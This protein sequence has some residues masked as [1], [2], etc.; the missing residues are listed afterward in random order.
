MTSKR[1]I[2]AFT[3]IEILITIVILSIGIVGILHAFETSMNSLTQTR[4][5]LFNT[6]LCRDKLTEIRS[7][8]VI[9]KAPDGTSAGAF[10]GTFKNY[11]WSTESS[12]VPRNVKSDSSG[13]GSDKD[14]STQID[15]YKLKVSVWRNGYPDDQQESVTYLRL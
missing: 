7:D 15:L 10:D 4:E 14:E 11:R 3:L 13:S 9:G 2:E 1:N 6:I 12:L 5:V 8:I